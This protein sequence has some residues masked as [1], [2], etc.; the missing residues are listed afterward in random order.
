[1]DLGETI[2]LMTTRTL[3]ALGLP[4]PRSTPIGLELVER[5]TINMLGVLEDIIISVDSWEYPVDFLLL[6]IQSKL[7]GH[8]L[9]LG[10]P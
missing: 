6:N 3:F 10:R 8:P 2:N 4:N 1:M 7:D 9:I 5:S